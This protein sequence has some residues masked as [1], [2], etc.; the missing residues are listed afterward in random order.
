[1]HIEK[2]VCD[3]IVNTL[4]GI[5]RKTNSRRDLKK[6]G[7]RGDLHLVPIGN[8]LFDL[9][10]SPYTLSPGLQ[11]L[12]CLI[13]KGVRFPVG[14]ASHIRKNVQVKKR[15]VVGLKSHDNHILLQYL[16]PLA[17]R[18]TLPQ[19]V[20]A[21]IIRVSMLFQ[22][23][24]SPIICISDMG[25]LEKEIVE[26]LSIL[27]TIFLPS[28]FDMMVHLMVHL[29]LQVRLGGPMKFSNMY[30]PERSFSQPENVHHITY[31]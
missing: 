8:D 30:A 13:L 26:T 23:K 25:E 24:Y 15:K 28:F 7:L 2:N 11:R 18:K 3:N 14:Y 16:L 17:M 21:A 10:S 6:L 29:P 1:M 9:P 4:L 19:A 22:K 5:E 27:E 31:M 12:F 20:S